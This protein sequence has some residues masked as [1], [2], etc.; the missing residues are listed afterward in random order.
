M[1][2]GG[3][4]RCSKHRASVTVVKLALTEW[5]K[6]DRPAPTARRE[7]SRAVVSPPP[8]SPRRDDEQARIGEQGLAVRLARVGLL[9]AAAIAGEKFV[10]LIIVEPLQERLQGR[11]GEPVRH[12]L[13][14]GGGRNGGRRPYG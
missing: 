10:A 1:T 3:L 13:R 9:E 4:I 2:S 6:V 14:P 7:R 8:P 12:F 11:T 5:I